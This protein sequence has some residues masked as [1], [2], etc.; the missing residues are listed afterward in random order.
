MDN[1]DYKILMLEESDKDEA[2]KLLNNNCPAE[3]GRYNMNRLDTEFLITSEYPF[4][5]RF[6]GAK[7]D[8]GSLIA[9]GGIKAA[10]WASDTHILYMMAVEQ[11]Y[12]G[13]GI[14][15]A[16]EKARLDWLKFNFDHGRCLVSTKHYKRFERLGFK[17]VSELENR[18]LMMLEF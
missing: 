9:V 12:R 18:H 15:A 1:I 8:D 3:S 14:G 11:S 10:D 5:K 7:F 16:L 6:F 17:S 13:Q 2:I 4:Y